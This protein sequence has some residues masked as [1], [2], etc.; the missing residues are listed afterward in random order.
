MF[1]NEIGARVYRDCPYIN[2]TNLVFSY[3]VVQSPL[4]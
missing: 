4:K 2:D 3:L 1:K